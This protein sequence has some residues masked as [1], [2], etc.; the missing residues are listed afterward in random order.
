[1]RKLSVLMITVLVLMLA[2][3]PALA[4][5]E[6]EAIAYGDVIEGQITDDAPEVFYTFEGTEGDVIVIDAFPTDTD[7]NMTGIA[8]ALLDAD[9]DEVEV[10]I[11]EYALARLWTELEESGTYTIVVRRS[12]YS[13]DTGL[14]IVRLIVPEELAAGET[15]TGEVDAEAPNTYY[16]FTTEE[17]FE[18]NIELDEAVRY[19]PRF[20]VY[21]VGWEYK[22]GDVAL[23]PSDNDTVVSSFKITPDKRSVYIFN[24]QFDNVARVYEDVRGSFEFTLVGEE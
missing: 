18:V 15:L 14:F 1:M 23:I 17:P 22:L 24:A 5:E 4:Q 19:V 3:V 12:E 13:D 2:V 20:Y 8:L 10:S 7:S 11:D 21:R 9:G 16:T 6:A